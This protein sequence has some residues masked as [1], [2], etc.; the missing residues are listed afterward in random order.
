MRM[1]ATLVV[2]SLFV[3]CNCP[4]GSTYRFPSVNIDW[5]VINPVVECRCIDNP[6]SEGLSR[7]LPIPLSAGRTLRQHKV[8]HL[9]AS[10]DGSLV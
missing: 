1:P 10:R 5:Q 6:G 8:M 2:L 3:L 9:H 4:K 7:E